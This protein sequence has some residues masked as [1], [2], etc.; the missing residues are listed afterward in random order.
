[1]S[2]WRL[3]PLLAL[4]VPLAARADATRVV[5]GARL[6]VVDL[7][8]DAGAEAGAVDLGP[9]PPP[10]GSRLV[11]RAEVLRHVRDA[12][13]DA[14]R[15]RVP[16]VVRV[17]GAARHL[18]A[19]EVTKLTR[20]AIERALPPGVTVVRSAATREIVVPPRAEVREATVPRAPR[21]KGAFHTIAMVEL[22]SDGVVVA[23][24]PIDVTLEV[25]EAA[26]RP[27]VARGAR[28]AI[29]VELS[30]VRVST[31]GTALADA[32]IGEVLTAQ[33]ASTGRVVRV[34]VVSHDEAQV[35]ETP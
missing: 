11:D 29:V 10:G 26:S 8:P 22:A 17:V 32:A 18:S 3:L 1:M 15:L 23:R 13:I 28:V 21:Q 30:G 35:V 16:Q 9:A 20:G 2:L 27:D 33:V 12:G 6:R 25:S 7:V 4:L 34:R 14:K 31:Y 24:V 19:D 5:E